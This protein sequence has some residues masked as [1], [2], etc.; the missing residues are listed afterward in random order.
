M[1]KDEADYGCCVRFAVLRFHRRRRKQAA[2]P[3]GAEPSASCS[4]GILV[5][6][7]VSEVLTAQL[8]TVCVVCQLGSYRLGRIHAIRVGVGMI[9]RGKVGMVAGQIG[10]SLGMISSRIYTGHQVVSGKILLLE[11][12]RG[13]TDITAGRTEFTA[14]GNLWRRSYVLP[15]K[16]SKASATEVN[17]SIPPSRASTPSLRNRSRTDDRASTA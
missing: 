11:F 15:R 1:N 13:R 12:I 7:T 5:G 17:R 8:N 14:N 16:P 2:R 9:P 6:D 3:P 10:L 4:H